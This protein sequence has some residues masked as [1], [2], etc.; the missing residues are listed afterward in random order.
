MPDCPNWR[1]RTRG[2]S[3]GLSA[4]RNAQFRGECEGGKR[5]ARSAFYRSQNWE[6]LTD[7]ERHKIV[8]EVM[9]VSTA[10]AAAVVCAM[11]LLYEPRAH[12]GAL[13]LGFAGPRVDSM[14]SPLR[15]FSAP[16]PLW[17]FSRRPAQC[18]HSWSR[19]TSRRRARVVAPY[20]YSHRSHGRASSALASLAAAKALKKGS[21]SSPS[22]SSRRPL[23]AWGS[24]RC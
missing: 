5:R 21:T 4:V 23:R 2:K 14:T 8:W 16:A 10:I 1:S 18:P 24:R 20:R 22:R 19:W 9:S 7:R 15:G 17:R 12:L 11:N 3:L 6:K 13:S